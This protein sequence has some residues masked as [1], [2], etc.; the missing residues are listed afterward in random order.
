MRL[1]KIFTSFYLI[2]FKFLIRQP[3]YFLSAM[4][5]PSL[6]FLIFAKQH[7]KT[8]EAGLL[9]LCSFSCFAVLGVV[10]LDTGVQYSKD[11][12][13]GWLE[14]LSSLPSPKWMYPLSKSLVLLTFSLLSASLVVATVTA[15]TP[16]EVGFKDLFILYGLLS[17][18]SLPF[19]FLGLTIGR[20]FSPD[21]SVAISNL[22]YL[23]LSFAG[24]LWMPPEALP[25]RIADVS[26]LLPTRFYGE[27]LWKNIVPKYETDLPYTS[28]LFVYS[29]IFLLMLLVANHF[30]SKK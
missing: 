12:N 26:S 18:G 17:L 13:T 27:L 9:L 10:I 2:H 1:I 14:Y 3:S 5:F 21:G 23:L 11:R 30:A 22:I 8:L 4:I 16:A 20:L 24:G 28:G 25:K 19:I 29:I 7:A 15:T 6:F